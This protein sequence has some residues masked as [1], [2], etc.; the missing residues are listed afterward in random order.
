MLVRIPPVA[1]MV[2]ETLMLH[3]EKRHSN[4]LSMNFLP[5]SHR[6]RRLMAP[7]EWRTYHQKCH[8]MQAEGY[9]HVHND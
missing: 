1:T 9:D 5:E 8:E 6:E 3:L 4:D 7:V 2:D